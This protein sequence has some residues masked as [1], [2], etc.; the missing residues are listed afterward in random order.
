MFCRNV[1]L[2][3]FLFVLDKQTN[4]M[5][6]LNIKQTF[7]LHALFCFLFEFAVTIIKKKDTEAL[8]VMS[9]MKER[10]IRAQDS[11]KFLI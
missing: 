11:F 10:F 9:Y 4:L 8:T 6:V 3:L 7:Y 5:F 1:E 2:G